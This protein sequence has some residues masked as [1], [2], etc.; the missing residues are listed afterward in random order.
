MKASRLLQLLL[1]LQTR[2]RITTAELAQRLE[3]S[4]RTVMRDVDA[5]SEA[6][7]PVYAERGRTGGICLLPGA[8]LNISALEP[9]ELEAL[10]V[11]GLDEE[12]LQRL[13]LDKE[14]TSAT[15]KIS[16]RR[17]PTVPPRSSLRSHPAAPPPRRLADLVIVEPTA[18]LSQNQDEVDITGLVEALRRGT[19][20]R[21]DYRPSSAPTASSRVVDPYGLVWKS[22]RWYLVADQDGSARLFALQRLTDFTALEAPAVLRPTATLRS[23]WEQLRTR[24]E[25]PGALEVVARLRSS[26]VDLAQRILGSRLHEVMDRDEDWCTIKLRYEQVEAVRQLLQFGDHIE[27]LEPSAARDRFRDLAAD[28]ARRHSHPVGQTHSTYHS[29]Y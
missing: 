10:T 23:T 8:R 18:W 1:L 16:T 6:G 24:T 22:G 7:V 19:R 17:P 12:Q 29:H 5:L 9:R 14:Y 26:R 27:V 28:L 2:Q 3:V 13:G 21:I 11:A 25:A 4:R 20:L 15:A